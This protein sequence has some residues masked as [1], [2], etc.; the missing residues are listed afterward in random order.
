MQISGIAAGCSLLPGWAT[1]EPDI[2]LE[3]A[4]YTLEASPKHRFKTLAYNGQV[5]GPLLRM[6]QG[7][8][9]TVEYRILLPTPRWCIGMACF[10][11]RK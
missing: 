3:I 8:T 9:Q 1:A 6:R 4:P 10:C 7:V 11:R 5:P 2:R